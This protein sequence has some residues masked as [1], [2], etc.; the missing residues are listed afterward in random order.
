MNTIKFSTF[1]VHSKFGHSKFANNK[2]ANNEFT[3]IGKLTRK[4]VAALLFLSLTASPLAGCDSPNARGLSPAVGSGEQPFTASGET[5]ALLSDAS[6][7]EERSQQPSTSADMVSP[8]VI[9]A[10]SPEEF[11]AAT[12][13][14]F[15]GNA[16]GQNRIYSP[17]NVYI[18]LAMLA[19][20][21]DGESREQLL[22]LLGTE[23]VETLRA[24]VSE[25]WD[26]NCRDDEISSILLAASLWTDKGL[27]LQSD[28]V[29]TLSE[30]YHA[31][32]HQGKMGSAGFN[33]EFQQ[34]LNDGTGG[35]LEQQVS[36]QHFSDDT[37]L[38]LASTLYFKCRWTEEFSGSKT[39]RETFHAKAEDILCD[40]MHQSRPMNFYRGE[41][42]TAVALDFMGGSRM[43]LLLP[44][45]DSSLEDLMQ[46][47]SGLTD[48]V[49]HPSDWE[50]T[51]YAIVNLSVP[52]FD[53]SSELDLSDLLRE[54]GITDIFTAKTADFSAIMDPDVDA[55]IS[56]I[57]HAARVKID[58]EGCEA[59]AFT[60]MMRCGA[61]MP[62]P[63]EVDFVADRPFVF[64][65]TG[66]GDL[67]LFTGVV[68]RP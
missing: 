56:E 49:T 17:A 1:F 31:T 66:A 11:Y 55:P 42:F 33:R 7:S 4:A 6:A 9:D 54:L 44:D 61:V 27:S 30:A 63:E 3:K 46:E 35:L 23:D 15:L 59:A 10:K 58:E 5:P 14:T 24:Y 39:A 26:G 21:T 53:V 8:K 16:D 19:E 32:T 67:P 43:W 40:F 68:T 20:I 64:V 18:A 60:T 22:T 2:F 57:T 52:K 47:E 28:T 12:I 51:Q 34:W 25:L 50:D 37:L 38:S 45:E 41:H 29:K 13:S 36:E 65:I 62:L 48:L